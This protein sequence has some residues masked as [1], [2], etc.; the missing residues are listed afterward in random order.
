MKTLFFKNG[1]PIATAVLAIAGAFATTSMQS[2]SKAF[3]PKVGYTLNA[4]NECEIAT[5]CNN[6]PSDE[7]CRV[8]YPGGALAYDRNPQGNCPTTL[9]RNR[10]Q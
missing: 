8:S 3:T 5:Q 4:S 6:M 2:S 10:G 9:W 7:I 1:M